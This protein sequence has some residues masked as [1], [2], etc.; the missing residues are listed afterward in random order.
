MRCIHYLLRGSLWGAPV[1]FHAELRR[2]FHREVGR[3][4]LWIS[5]HAGAKGGFCPSFS[6]RCG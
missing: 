2:F 5:G 4:W 6:V 1:D 3:L